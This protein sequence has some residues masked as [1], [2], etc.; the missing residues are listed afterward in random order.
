V[1]VHRRDHGALLVGLATATAHGEPLPAVAR[2]W[3]HRRRPGEAVRPEDDVA[4]AASAVR[5]VSATLPGGLGRLFDEAA[6]G[7]CPDA[8]AV[9]DRLDA[10]ALAAFGPPA[11]HPIP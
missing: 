3:T 8:W 7:G 10:E 9:R 6:A 2:G 4:M 11:Y 1:L 5:T